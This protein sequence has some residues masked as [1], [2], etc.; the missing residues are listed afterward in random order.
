MLHYHGVIPLPPSLIDA[1]DYTDDGFKDAKIA[2][3]EGGEILPEV[4]SSKVKFIPQNTLI[5]AFFRQ[6]IS[7]INER[8]FKYD[9]DFGYSEK[10]L[11]Y[12]KYYVGDHYKWH[13][14]IIPNKVRKLSFSVVMNDDFEGGEF[15][16]ATP[17]S[18]LKYNSEEVFFD[19]EYTIHTVPTELGSVIVFPSDN[20]HRVKPVTKGVRK[21]IVGWITGPPFR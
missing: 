19:Q 20:F 16:I 14:D 18:N 10:T 6:H 1:I 9:L 17:T 12:A 4:R 15:Q 2:T 8:Y 21:S 7:E 5:G 13:T 11:Q 3:K